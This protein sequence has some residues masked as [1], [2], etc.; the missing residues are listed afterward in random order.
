M[1]INGE[2]RKVR[3]VCPHCDEEHTVRVETSELSWFI[4]MEILWGGMVCPECFDF[5]ARAY[6][7]AQVSQ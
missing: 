7:L 6:H 3:T 1:Q 4:K 2:G 5:G